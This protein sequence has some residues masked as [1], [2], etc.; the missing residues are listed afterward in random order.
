LLIDAVAGA[1]AQAGKLWRYTA[2]YHGLTA[3]TEADGGFFFGRDNKTVEV[4]AGLASTSDRIPVLFGNSGVGKSS[5]AQAGV[6]SCLRR[7]DWPEHL[8]NGEAWPHDF[9]DSRSWCFLTM[10]PGEE[11]L[12]E[13]VEPFLR[14]WQLDPTGTLWAQ[15]QSEWVSALADGKLSLRDLLDATHRRF[16][17]LNQPRPALLLSLHRPGRGALRAREGASAYAFLCH[18]CGQHC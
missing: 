12:K 7:Q 13:L 10:R 1:D 18:H 8:T 4:I 3:M 17:E 15:R 11:P 6:L 9:H 14:A 16:D 2:P 5:L